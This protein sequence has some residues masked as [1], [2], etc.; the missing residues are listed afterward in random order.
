VWVPH[1]VTSPASKPALAWAPLSTDPQV[2]PE[3]CSSTGFP[4]SHSFLQASTCSGMVSSM[5]FRWISGPPWTPMSCRRTACLNLA[6][7]V[8]YRGISA[9]VPGTPSSP[10]SSLAL[11][12]A[13]LFLS[14]S[15]T[16]SCCKL[17]LRRFFSLVK[18]I[19]TEVLP[20][21]LIVLALGS[22]GSILEPAGTGCTRHKGSF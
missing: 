22:S 15:L 6:Y 16:L 5:G 14:H 7:S 20:H 11:V 2:L 8:V 10:P 18:T 19:V 21:L 3:A 4:L 13:E 17:L 9:P 1:G 12:S